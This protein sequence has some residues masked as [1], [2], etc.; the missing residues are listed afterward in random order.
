MD[1]I[2]RKMEKPDSC[3][4]CPILD[5]TGLCNLQSEERNNKALTYEQLFMNCPIE[6]LQ[7]GSDTFQSE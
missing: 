4:S 3:K 7:P 5:S 6:E 1:V 2:I